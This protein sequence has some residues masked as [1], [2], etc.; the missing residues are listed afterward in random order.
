M[1]TRK[2]Q[3]TVVVI[4]RNEYFADPKV[5]IDISKYKEPGPKFPDGSINWQCPCM[6]GGSLVSH[7][8][9]NFFRELYIC[10]K[11]DESKDASVKCPNQF[12]NWAA[13][14]QNMSAEKR[15]MMRKAM[16]ETTTS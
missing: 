10:M 1:I 14:M 5:Q 16:T 2:N 8:C 9:G 4:N 7:R 13:C 11:S 15:E 6:A 3:D 12:V